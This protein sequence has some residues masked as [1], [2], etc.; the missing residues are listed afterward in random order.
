MNLDS[1]TDLAYRNSISPAKQ[2]RSTIRRRTRSFDAN[3]KKLILERA[4]NL[5]LGEH[6]EM[7]IRDRG[8]DSETKP[9][10][11]ASNFG[12]YS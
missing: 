11:R 8:F 1:R 6:G 5:E 10:R 4:S 7:G 9:I 12:A 3:R 2:I